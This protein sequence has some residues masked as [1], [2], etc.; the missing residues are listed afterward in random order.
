MADTPQPRRSDGN[1]SPLPSGSL[2]GFLHSCW[3]RFKEMLQLGWLDQ[4]QDGGDD[5]NNHQVERIAVAAPTLFSRND[6]DGICDAESSEWTFNMRKWWLKHLNENETINED[7]HQLVKSNQIAR[8]DY[9]RNDHYS[10][11]SKVSLRKYFGADELTDLIIEANGDRDGTSS[12]T[13][14]GHAAILE[15][16]TD[17]FTVCLRDCWSQS[18]EGNIVSLDCNPDILLLL[19]RYFYFGELQSIPPDSLI[20]CLTLSHQLMSHALTKVLERMIASH[21][22]TQNVCSILNLAEA[23]NL[24][25][26]K[27]KCL[28]TS[29]KNL[30]NIQ[31]LEYF[32]DLSPTVQAALGELRRSYDQSKSLYGDTFHFIRELLS[33]IKDSIDE[34]EEAYHISKLRNLE[35][36]EKCDEKLRRINLV[37]PFPTTL[38]LEYPYDQDIVD[39][40]RRLESV[41]INLQIQRDQL[42]Q[43]KEFYEQQKRSLDVFY[44][45]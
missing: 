30:Q 18:R 45:A 24:P 15:A 34:G 23:L 21:I 13:F 22:D 6:G 3:K 11:F 35:E 39:W 43:R 26:L 38:A 44:G 37:Y 28:I 14:K 32:R 40:R 10:L 31:H 27:E 7:I 25:Y 5:E 29:I 12:R 8:E 17:F 42:N 41:E 36:I 2:E 1:F 16:H 19:M 9:F 4:I 20:S 33:M